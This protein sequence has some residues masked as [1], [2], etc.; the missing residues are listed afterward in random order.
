MRT[1]ICF[2]WIHIEE[3]SL[4]PIQ[5]A[6]VGWQGISPTSLINAGKLK[7]HISDQNGIRKKLHKPTDRLPETQS[8]ITPLNLDSKE[9]TGL[10]PIWILIIPEHPARTAK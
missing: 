4:Y 7:F 10:S 9:D 8:I 3:T 2:S 6:I 1:R 5:A